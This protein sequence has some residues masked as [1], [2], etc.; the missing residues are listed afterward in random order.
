[1]AVA[2]PGG[3]WV[4][5]EQGRQISEVLN[6]PALTNNN[7]SS[8]M[9]AAGPAAGEGHTQ[10]GRLVPSQGSAAHALLLFLSI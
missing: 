2:L 3:R 8:L 9:V 6:R 5:T 7:V 10:P 1:M 4:W